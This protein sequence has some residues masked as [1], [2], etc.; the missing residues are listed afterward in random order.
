MSSLNI[1]VGGQVTTVQLGTLSAAVNQQITQAVASTTASAASASASASSAGASATSA[2]TNAAS[3]GTSASSASTSALGASTSA[4]NAATSATQAAASAAGIYIHPGPTG[5][6]TGVL[7]TANLA[8]ALARGGLIEVRAPGT[9]YYNATNVIQ[10][11]TELRL[12]R[13]VLWKQVAGTS[14]PFLKN[15]SFSAST[16][17]VA[18]FAASGIVGTISV[19]GHGRSI[20]DYVAVLGS[21][22]YGYNGVFRVNAVPDANTLTVE[23]PV[24]PKTATA[25]SGIE[26]VSATPGAAGT[27]YTVGDVLTVSGG[28]FT[29]SAQF[30]VASV[31]AGAITGV[32]LTTPGVYT[33]QIP[34]SAFQPGAV[35]GGTGTGATLK[36]IW[37]VSSQTVVTGMTL[38]LADAHIS[39]VGEGMVDYD[40]ANN[41]SSFGTNWVTHTLK[42]IFDLTL[43][44]VRVLNSRKYAW[45]VANCRNVK[46]PKLTFNTSSDGLHVMGPCYGLDVGVL[47]GT[48][49]DDMLAFTLG[50]YSQY[51]VSRGD[52]ENVHV[53][54]LMPQGSLTALKLTGNAPYKVHDVYVDKIGG[55]T[56]NS[57][58]Y[59]QNDLNLTQTDIGRL[60]VGDLRG[61]GNQS[62]GNWADVFLRTNQVDH[63][64]IRSAT[65]LRLDS[66]P[67]IG[68]D[69]SSYV[70]RLSV[71][72][73][74]HRA[75]GTPDLIAVS[76][77]ARID[78]LDVDAT[79]VSLGSTGSWVYLYNT[80][81]SIG[82]INI[83]G[84]S[85]PVSGSTARVIR[86][87][88]Q[89]DKVRFTNFTIV[90][91]HSLLDQSQATAALPS[92]EIDLCNVIGDGFTTGF[93]IRNNANIRS[94]S[95]RLTSVGGGIPIAV[96]GGGFTA[97]PVLDFSGS[98][99]QATG[100]RC[101][102]LST[103][104]I[105]YVNGPTTQNDVISHQTLRE[106][107]VV[108][109]TNSGVWPGIGAVACDGKYWRRLVR[110]ALTDTAHSTLSYNCVNGTVFVV[111]PL[112]INVAVAA[113]TNV[114]PPADEVEFL[115]TQDATGGRTITWDA[116]FKFATAWAD[117]SN[118]ANKKRQ[119][120][121]TSDGSGSFA[122][123]ADSGWY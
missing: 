9:Y 5:D 57:L 66:Y 36:V 7:D 117:G 17:P 119:V 112:T 82:E 51:E 109:N 108:Y 29:T 24:P 115:F 63:F 111:G 21:T 31:N 77:V 40:Q 84:K 106:G 103:G 41:S 1:T 52:V 118:G 73:L 45:L 122:L 46:V 123:K 4:T 27:G 54:A 113:L 28:T 22:S 96:T 60:I 62:G 104:G 99:T 61:W 53:G 37:Q 10:T 18:S 105:V 15:T 6:A 16:L 72:N 49:G 79:E 32:T 8:T 14:R 44:G 102:R 55:S 70:K 23:L 65:R 2:S 12:H 116:S 91:G 83:S 90:G 114:P 75:N 11:K 64:E 56:Q 97:A 76:S 74:Q 100:G 71:G 59:A 42:N 13:G 67:F 26:A 48:T 110:K 58:I 86:H 39:I 87:L 38:A 93:D 121:F 92:V 80:G 3:A 68:V 69:S 85:S 78:V 101:F 98:L 43:D 20:G 33:G 88:G 19:T 107:D 25:T 120:I 94:A 30:T 50:D 34:A 95:S 81:A 89:I 35:T 47:Q